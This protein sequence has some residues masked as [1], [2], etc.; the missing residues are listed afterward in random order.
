MFIYVC[1]HG[2]IACVIQN[3]SRTKLVR[4]THCIQ[5]LELV[6]I[7]SMKADRRLHNKCVYKCTQLLSQTDLLARSQQVT[8]TLLRTRFLTVYYALTLAWRTLSL[9]ASLRRSRSASLL[10]ICCKW[11][12]QQSAHVRMRIH[13]HIYW[14][15]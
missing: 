12:E 6:G 14:P 1:M 2:T 8:L 13:T 5:T 15:H 10:P 3:F 11:S 7:S 9:S 4:R